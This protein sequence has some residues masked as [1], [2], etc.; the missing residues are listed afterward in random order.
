MANKSKSSEIVYYKC[1][2]CLIIGIIYTDLT[3]IVCGVCREWVNLGSNVTTEE[4]YK[5]LWA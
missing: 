1:G 2:R 4:A 3:Y 5:K